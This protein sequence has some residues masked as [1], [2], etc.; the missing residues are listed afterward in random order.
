MPFL[1]GSALTAE[2]MVALL[3]RSEFD[4]ASLGS[5]RRAVSGCLIVSGLPLDRAED[6]TLAVAEMLGNAIEHGGGGGTIAMTRE[7]R[8]LHCVITDEGPGLPDGL[9][10]PRWDRVAPAAVDGR[11]LWLAY[12]LCSAVTLHSSMHGT[13]V[14]LLMD[15]PADAPPL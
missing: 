10:L 2:P 5:V 3:Y 6:A 9:D 11:G 14:D 7:D 4:L 12:T 13:R 15:L 8:Q 1:P